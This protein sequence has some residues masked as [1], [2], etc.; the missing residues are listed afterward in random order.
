MQVYS[1]I[2]SEQIDR[3]GLYHVSDSFFDFTV[4]IEYKYRKYIDTRLEPASDVACKITW[5][6]HT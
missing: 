5:I 6:V 2:W 1:S 4:A 3:G